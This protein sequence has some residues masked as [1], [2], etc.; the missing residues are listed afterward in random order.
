MLTP[1][2]G[3]EALP[4]PCCILPMTLAHFVDSIILTQIFTSFSKTVDNSP[5]FADEKVEALKI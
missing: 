3:H 2:L 1:H 5:Q 4:W